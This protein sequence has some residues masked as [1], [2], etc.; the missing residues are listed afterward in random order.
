[1]AS[2]SNSAGSSW[3]VLP[4]IG[5]GCGAG[6]NRP[7]VETIDR[8]WLG[9]RK[10]DA[11]V[12]LAPPSSG[13][14]KAGW[15]PS[16]A[17]SDLRAGI[18]QRIINPKRASVDPI[19][20]RE[21]ERERIDRQATPRHREV[22]DGS[23]RSPAPATRS[24][25][26]GRSR[27]G[28]WGRL[29]ADADLSLATCPTIGNRMGEWLG[30]SGP[31]CQSNSRPSASGREQSSAP[32]AL[33]VALIPPPAIRC[34]SVIPFSSLARASVAGYALPVDEVSHRARHPLAVRGA[35]ARDGDEV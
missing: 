15:A 35:F 14:R 19:G 21:A 2:C 29:V 5:V 31:A 12:A 23:D 18:G 26:G 7:A 16:E 34:R 6:F 25:G 9:G 1:M 28:S 13:Q 11:V 4:S 33:I 3:R 22:R 8:R 24:G 27:A 17:G 30:Q 20:E 32:S 10:L